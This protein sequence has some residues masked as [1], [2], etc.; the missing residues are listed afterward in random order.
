M[1]RERKNPFDSEEQCLSRCQ[2]LTIPKIYLE[3]LKFFDAPRLIPKV[4][5]GQAP[6]HPL[7]N[8]FVKLGTKLKDYSFGRQRPHTPLYLK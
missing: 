3:L 8:T 2:F 6:P 4:G 7:T 5:G 1:L